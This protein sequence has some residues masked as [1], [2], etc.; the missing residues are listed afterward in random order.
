MYTYI[1]MTVVIHKII[2]RLHVRSTC[3]H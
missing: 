2:R 1:N 3:D